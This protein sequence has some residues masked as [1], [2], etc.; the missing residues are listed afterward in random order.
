MISDVVGNKIIKN[1]AGMIRNTIDSIDENDFHTLNIC[2]SFK[3]G[4]NNFNTLSISLTHVKYDS[5]VEDIESMI[6]YDAGYI[7]IENAMIEASDILTAYVS[8]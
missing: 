8:L 1:I 4:T 7:F 5:C 6:Y 2:I 3:S